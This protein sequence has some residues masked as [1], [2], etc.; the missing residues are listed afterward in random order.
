MGDITNFASRSMAASEGPSLSGRGPD[1]LPEQG[2]DHADALLDGLASNAGTNAVHRG[3]RTRL[4]V[5][6]H[7]ASRWVLREASGSADSRR[8]HCRELARR[9]RSGGWPEERRGRTDS[10]PLAGA[11]GGA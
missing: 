10:R 3:V 7:I 9:T 6:L 1:T 4:L 11:A 5:H 8:P 2:D